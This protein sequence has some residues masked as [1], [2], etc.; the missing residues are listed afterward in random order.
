MATI[1]VLPAVGPPVPEYFDEKASEKG[2][3]T[4]ERDFLDT[5]SDIGEV[6]DDVRAI[7]MG[8]DG[9]EKPIGRFTSWHPSA[10]N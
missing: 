5:D 7:D 3:D 8:E 1:E 2:S 4:K 9:K 6:C 10:H